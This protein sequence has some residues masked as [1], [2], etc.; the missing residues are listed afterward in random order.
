[1]NGHALDLIRSWFPGDGYPLPDESMVVER[2]GEIV[3][4]VGLFWRT[5]ETD[6]G[7]LDVGGIGLVCT[8]PTWRGLGLATAL[9]QTAY[10][11]SCLHQR[12][13][14]ALYAG[15]AESVF[16]LARG[17]RDGGGVPNLYVGGAATGEIISG[18]LW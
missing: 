14:V 5:L 3:S 10:R 12:P 7:P 8:H 15:E 6:R 17:F 16:Y 11:R 4:H 9:L 2:H 18:P 13:V 1:M